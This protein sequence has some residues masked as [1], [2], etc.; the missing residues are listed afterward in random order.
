MS[1][2][3]GCPVRSVTGEVPTSSRWRR[4]FSVLLSR[5]W[6]SDRSQAT[7]QAPSSWRRTGICES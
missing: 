4:N 6:T 2:F 5:G 7:F 3:R 1:V